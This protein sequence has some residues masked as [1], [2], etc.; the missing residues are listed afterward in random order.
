MTLAEIVRILN[1]NV[2][3]GEGG[4]DKDVP[5]AFASDLMSDVLAFATANGVLLTG[6]TTPQ[7]V[8]T[9]DVSDISAIILVGGKRPSQ[10]M[11]DLATTLEIPLFSTKYVMF[12]AAGRLFREGLVGAQQQPL[13]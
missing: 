13:F 8:R 11:V 9:A 5:H 4:L 1:A 3:F 10:E 12:E 2:L 6:L 7:V